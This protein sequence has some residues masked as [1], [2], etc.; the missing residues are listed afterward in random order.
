LARAGS[1]PR[2]LLVFVALSCWATLAGACSC[3]GISASH[4]FEHSDFVF[5]GRVISREGAP[6][7]PVVGADGD[8]TWWHSSADMVRYRMVATEGWKGEPS[9]TITI[10][11]EVS[12]ISCGFEFQVG[13]SYLVYAYVMTEDWWVRG[14]PVGAT[15]P[16]L[17]TNLCSR[18]RELDRAAEDLAWL[19]NAAWI[20]SPT[21]AALHL[22]QNQPNPFNPATKIT[23][24]LPLPGHATLRVFDTSGR[25]VRTLLDREMPAGTFARSWDGKDERGR[26][27]RSGVFFYELSSGALRETRRMTLIR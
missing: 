11:S 18:T 4:A 3:I 20:L 23:F 1:V 13:Q 10:Y 16:V 22:S 6:A 8:T 27:V 14:W 17:S 25:L 21:P 26:A 2:L 15:F 7:T 12:E 19:G 9:D 24:E 5:T